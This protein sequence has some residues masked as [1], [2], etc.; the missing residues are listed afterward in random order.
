VVIDRLLLP[1]GTIE[2][3]YYSRHALQKS[4][5]TVLIFIMFY[6]QTLEGQE[7]S[8]LNC[9]FINNSTQIVSSGTDGVIKVWLIKSGEVVS[10]LD[11]HAARVWAL[12]GN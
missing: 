9:A 7:C 2:V 8:V 11:K 5:R 4:T 1:K 12:T 6:R 10:T 3:E